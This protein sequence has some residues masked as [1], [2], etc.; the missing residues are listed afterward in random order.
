MSHSFPSDREIVITRVFDAPR[1]RVFA[2]WTG[3]DVDSWWGPTGF[4]TTTSSRDFRPGGEWIYQMKHPEH[5][6]F[7][8]RIRYHE[9]VPPERIT[10]RHDGGEE[11]P[12]GGFDVVVRFVDR[13]GRTEVTMHTTLAS[14]EDLAAAL[15]YNAIAGGEQTMDRF[16]ASLTDG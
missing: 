8:N 5:G 2:A 13:D 6:E 9:I 1:A 10:Y 4:V 11:D 14:A 16:E 3:P 12:V 7:P 15:K